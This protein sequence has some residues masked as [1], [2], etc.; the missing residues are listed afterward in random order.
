MER[1]PLPNLRT[2]ND[3]DVHYEMH[4]REST[5][6]FDQNNVEVINSSIRQKIELEK[7]SKYEVKIIFYSELLMI[8]VF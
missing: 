8:C 2:G 3:D 4:T 6:L 7:W 1:I 5:I